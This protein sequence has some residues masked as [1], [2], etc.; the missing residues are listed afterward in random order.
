MKIRE[1]VTL[2]CCEYCNKHYLRKHFCIAHE[3]NCRANPIN[4]HPCFDCPFL[5]PG[6]R[7]V[8]YDAWD[9]EH[10]TE[11]RSFA[12]TARGIPVYSYKVEAMS[13]VHSDMEEGERMPTD[14]EGC[15]YKAGTATPIPTAMDSLKSDYRFISFE[16]QD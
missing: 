3:P 12:C 8:F 15:P 13:R 6:K 2:F 11:I 5:L 1:N 14:E 10:S 4:Q 7:T 9:G 16:E